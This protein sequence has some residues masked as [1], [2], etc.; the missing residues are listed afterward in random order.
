MDLTESLGEKSL[1]KTARQPQQNLWINRI[2][3]EMSIPHKLL[4]LC[5]TGQPS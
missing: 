5:A 3:A 4:S 2:S 1:G